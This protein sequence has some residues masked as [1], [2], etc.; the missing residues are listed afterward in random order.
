MNSK[1]YLIIVLLFL[2]IFIFNLKDFFAVDYNT[3]VDFDIFKQLEINE[4]NNLWIPFEILK[5]VI[6][7]LGLLP[8]L[9]SISVLFCFLI[10]HFYS[11]KLF[12]NPFLSSFLLLFNP[13]VYSRIISGQIGV[14]F[15]YTFLIVSTYY[16]IKLFREDMSVKNVI[17]LG[18]SSTIMCSFQPQTAFLL[19]IIFIISSF[20]FWNKI[21]RV[22][23]KRA[24]LLFILLILLNSFWIQGVLSTNY[25]DSSG[26]AD[27][28]F[29]APQLSQGV[30]TTVKIIGGW[31]FW[32][33]VAYLTSYNLFPL[34]L[35][36]SLTFIFLGLMFI[37][38]FSTNSK[39]SKLFY[40][41]WWVGLLLA[42]GA[43]HPFTKPFFDFAFNNIP[44]F[45]GFRDSHKFVMLIMLAY[46]RLCPLG[47]N[48]IKNK[49]KLNNKITN[50]ALIV[51]ILVYSFPLI[52]LWNQVKPVNYPSSY[53][54]TNQ[55][56]LDENITGWLIYLPWEAYLTYD[57]SVNASSDGRISVPINYLV[58]PYV[59]VSPG[60][61]GDQDEFSNNISECLE[62]QSVSCLENNN[63][64]Y[65]LRDDCTF[66]PNNYSWINNTLVHKSDCLTLFE[67]N[68][69]KKVEYDIP[70]RFIIGSLISLTTF[71]VIL[72]YLFK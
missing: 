54:E 67:L 47:L 18:L 56:L 35:W 20:C 71:I 6:Y 49:F 4:F 22:Y 14:L 42:I 34:W 28:E 48:W 66:Y 68:S 61:W 11:K 51:F 33:E 44:F 8:Y 12:K 24:S 59:I 26:E 27:I 53:D 69:S 57:W 39:E 36:Y 21:K 62:V 52:G 38:Y 70:Q 40:F 16:I 41:L 72:I 13:F 60:S 50:I 37:G 65:V 58:E 7:S 64:Q 3:F 29:F 9:F 55:F 63:V 45:S 23:V 31:G 43:S 46:A 32:R 1:D 17:K 25:F 2:S 15:S 5:F 19:L 10:V 30:S